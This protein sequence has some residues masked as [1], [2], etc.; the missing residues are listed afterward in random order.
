MERTKVNE[1]TDTLVY[2]RCVVPTTFHEAIQQCGPKRSKKDFLVA[3]RTQHVVFSEQE[4]K[5]NGPKISAPTVE[6]EI[7]DSS[8]VSMSWMSDVQIRLC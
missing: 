2:I 5:R 7:T 3:A 6:F 8:I 4:R 1:C